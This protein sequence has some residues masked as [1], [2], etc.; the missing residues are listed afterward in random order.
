LEWI[1]GVLYGTAIPGPGGPS[2]LR[3][4]DPFIGTSTLIGATGLG[5][6]S[7]LAYE[8]TSDT[9]YGIAG[10]RGLSNL[11]TI[12]RVTGTAFLVGVTGFQAGSLEFGP[13]GQLYGGGSG[14]DAGNFYRIDPASGSSVLVG[15]TGFGPTTGLLLGTNLAG[16]SSL[17]S[18]EPIGADTYE[19][20]LLRGQTFTTSTETLLDH[21]LS[22][23]ANGL[24]PSLAILDPDGQVVAF[25]ADS[26]DGKNAELQFTAGTSGTYSIQVQAETGSGTYLL[27][28]NKG[29]MPADF[30]DDLDI[31]G[32]DFLIWQRGFSST[33][34]TTAIA[35][36]A[37]EDGIVDG[38]DQTYWQEGFGATLPEEVETT[39]NI[40]INSETGNFDNRFN[41]A[42]FLDW[43]RE[44]GTV[45][46]SSSAVG[47]SN[48]DGAV[49][50]QD[51]AYWE[52][53][54]GT[55][56]L[57]VSSSPSQA[58]LFTQGLFTQGESV[59]AISSDS[60]GA[61]SSSGDLA[62]NILTGLGMTGLGT[63]RQQ[64]NRLPLP[65]DFWTTYKP[66]SHDFDGNHLRPAARSQSELDSPW[67]FNRD[68]IGT[69]GSLSDLVDSDLVDTDR[70]VGRGMETPADSIEERE[71]SKYTDLALSQKNDWRFSLG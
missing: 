48:H 65:D 12:D 60:S 45:A 47:D 25:D 14:G 5:P 29:P 44:Y 21:P 15:Q 3:I 56:V 6:I 49:D 7:G 57:A 46:N 52:A 35:G 64:G 62:T 51:L 34:D 50:S 36:D 26:L 53:N 4:L 2:E 61:S 67:Q 71:E 22:T 54:F 41:G 16:V 69:A 1:D 40:A 19:I 33:S 70:P 63:Y 55:A 10:G 30:D 20:E 13:D 17:L 43:Q 32:F 18:D 24:N 27:H 8:P 28:T 66:T 11:Y 23:P 59:S 37:N 9:L 38:L 31:D 42:D 68:V 39:P 58:I